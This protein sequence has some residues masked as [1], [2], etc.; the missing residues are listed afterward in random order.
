MVDVC[1]TDIVKHTSPREP[2]SAQVTSGVVVKPS[3]RTLGCTLAIAA[4]KSPIVMARPLHKF[5]HHVR[6]V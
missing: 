4:S 1:E 6:T 5:S 3:R 2:T